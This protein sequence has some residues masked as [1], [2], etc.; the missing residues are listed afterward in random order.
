MN[1]NFRKNLVKLIL[2]ATLLSS[3]AGGALSAMA[4]G[5]TAS[6]YVN[7]RTG[8]GTDYSVESVVSPGTIVNIVSEMGTWSKV[9]IS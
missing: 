5:A 7:F 1:T 6:D 8:P 2:S 9:E 3:V 4:A